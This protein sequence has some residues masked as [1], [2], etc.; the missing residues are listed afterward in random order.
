VIVAAATH[1]HD[2]LAR[3]AIER[4]IPALLEKPVTSTAE[5]AVALAATAAAAGARIVPAHNM[6]HAP[7]IEALLTQAPSRAA[8]GYVWRRTARSADALRTWNRSSL[9]ET[10]YHLLVV[11]GRA[12][13]GGSGTIVTAAVRGDSAPESIRLEVHY[14]LATAEVV[15]DCAAA[16]EEDVLSRREGRY[17]ATELVWRRQGRTVTIATAAGVH[18]VEPRG[19]DVECMLAHFRD[20]VTRHGGAGDDA[21]GR[22]RRHAD[23]AARPSTRWRRPAPRSNG[24]TRPST[25]PRDS[26]RHRSASRR[27]A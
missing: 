11:V 20:V 23:R 21:R 15:L 7:G 6:L 5:Q 9:Y 27:P 24:R 17:P 1:A 25:S 8:V 26:C 16:V 10:L 13:G 14:G 12:A 18:A 2:A 3:L 4:G 22:G 19:S